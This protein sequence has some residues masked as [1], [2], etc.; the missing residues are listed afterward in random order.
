MRG[1]SWE[2]AQ[3]G[4]CRRERA[5]SALCHNWVLV[6]RARVEQSGFV[7]RDGCFGIVFARGM[8]MS[9][10]PGIGLV[11]IFKH[12]GSVAAFRFEDVLQV[13]VISVLSLIVRFV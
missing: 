5:L 3:P 4:H 10:A 6:Q 13:L 7:L 2:W 9:Q 8:G 1:Q 12:S 11:A